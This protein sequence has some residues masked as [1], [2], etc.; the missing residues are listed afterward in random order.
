MNYKKK[1][2]I[3]LKDKCANQ[4]F[5]REVWWR[6][7]ITSEK[8]YTYNTLLNLDNLV[9]KYVVPSNRQTRITSSCKDNLYNNWKNLP[10]Y[11]FF[12]FMDNS[13]STSSVLEIFCGQKNIFKVS[14]CIQIYWYML[15]QNAKK[16][17]FSLQELSNDT[18]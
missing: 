10:W 6:I 8:T 15:E 5:W 18:G 16:Y 7:Y 2:A 1:G 14:R 9:W 11:H 12:L 13:S 3:M 4:K 17:H